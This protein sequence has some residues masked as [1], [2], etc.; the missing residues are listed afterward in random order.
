[1]LRAETAMSSLVIRWGDVP[2]SCQRLWTKIFS[3]PTDSSQST[4]LIKFSTRIDQKCMRN[5]PEAILDEKGSQEVEPHPN[6][7]R[8]RPLITTPRSKNNTQRYALNLR[9]VTEFKAFLI[10]L[11]LCFINA[12]MNMSMNRCCCSSAAPFNT[13]IIFNEYTINIF[14]RAVRNKRMSV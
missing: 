10:R 3:G 5:C 2:W 12:P 4:R 13:L 11:V 1:M 14:W 9:Y 8:F 6:A 7:E